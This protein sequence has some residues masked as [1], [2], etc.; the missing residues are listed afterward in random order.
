MCKRGCCWSPWSYWSVCGMNHK[1]ECHWGDARD[2]NP[3]YVPVHWLAHKCEKEF[4]E[5]CAP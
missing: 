4:C 1:C 5:V 2:Y 3:L